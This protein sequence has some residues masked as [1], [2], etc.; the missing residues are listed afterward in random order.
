MAK[1][2]MMWPPTSLK[3]VIELGVGSTCKM[4]ENDCIK[5][6]WYN[7]IRDKGQIR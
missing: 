5:T 3:E 1:M 2:F 4:I 6:E 7:K